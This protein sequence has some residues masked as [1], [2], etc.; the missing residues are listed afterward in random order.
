MRRHFDDVKMLSR[1]IIDYDEEVPK[2]P[3][4]VI[5]NTIKGKG[6]SFFEN[7][8]ES[9]YAVLDEKNYKIALKEL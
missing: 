2:R 4:V 8:L 6:I 1:A 5:A 7:K 3:T 9:H